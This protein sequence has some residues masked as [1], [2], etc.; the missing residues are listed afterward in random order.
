[1]VTCGPSLAKQTGTADEACDCRAGFAAPTPGCGMLASCCLGMGVQGV[2][3]IKQHVQRDMHAQ[4]IRGESYECTVCLAYHPLRPC[5]AVLSA[6]SKGTAGSCFFRS[7]SFVLWPCQNQMAHAHPHSPLPPPSHP[8]NHPTSTPTT[9]HTEEGGVWGVAVQL[10]FPAPVQHINSAMP[11]LPP[12]LPHTLPL[13]QHLPPLGKA[14]T[15]FVLQA[16]PPTSPWPA[17]RIAALLSE[18]DPGELP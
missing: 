15:V 7:T 4:Q 1:M 3:Q 12:C 16:P 5:P 13:K 6:L 10:L 14:M 2:C 11:R 18:E 17:L 9:P 8:H